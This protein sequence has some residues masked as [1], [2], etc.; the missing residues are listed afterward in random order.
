MVNKKKG[1]W[2]L[3][4]TLVLFIIFLLIPIGESVTL[5][6]QSIRGNVSHFVGFQNFTKIISDPVFWSS[7][8]NSFIFLIIQVPIMLIVAIVLA[9][10]L[11]SKKLVFKTGF[12]LAIFLPCVTSLVSYSILFK[13][14]FSEDGLVNKFLVDIIGIM[15]QPIAWLQDPFWAKVVIILALLWRWTGYNMLFFLSSLQNIDD[16]VYE[17][18]IMDGANAFQ[19]FHFIT[20]PLLKPIILFTFIQSTIGTIQLF[21]EPMNLTMGGPANST[22]TVS[23]YIYNLGFKYLP[24]FG[25]AAAVSYVVMF[26]ILIL[27]VLQMRA[28][29]SKS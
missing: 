24:N 28:A 22:M 2:F 4:P 3:A 23:M 27:S 13:M 8:K 9:T 26:I 11:N 25:Y 15:N 14:L 16:E 5:V 21:D 1:W 7:L 10:M 12:R 19:K 20:L 17:A 29:R 18:A 6:F